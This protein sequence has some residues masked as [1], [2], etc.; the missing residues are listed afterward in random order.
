MTRRRSCSVRVFSHN[1]QWAPAEASRSRFSSC[2]WIS[3]CNVSHAWGR[4][5]SNCTLMATPSVRICSRRLLCCSTSASCCWM[6]STCRCKVG[7]VASLQLPVALTIKQR[8]LFQFERVAFLLHAKLDLVFFLLE[9]VAFLQRLG[10]SCV[11]LACLL[12]RAIGCSNAGS[13]LQ[14]RFAQLDFLLKLLLA[15]A[16]AALLEFQ[17]ILLG[18]DRPA[19]ALS[20]AAA[21]WCIPR[22]ERYTR[23]PAL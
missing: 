16:R 14:E 5:V 10:H 23:A 2:S 12:E 7:S 18:R 21:A 22:P 9:P 4:L 13:I 20:G 1:G 6:S 19:A 15:L 11:T 3:F 17:A 8:T